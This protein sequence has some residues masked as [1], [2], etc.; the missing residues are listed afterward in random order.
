M[1]PCNRRRATV[2]ESVQHPDDLDL[3]SATQPEP[4]RLKDLGS[5]SPSWG[6]HQE[7][8]LCPEVH[9]VLDVESQLGMEDPS[10]SSKMLTQHGNLPVLEAVDVAISQEV[11]LPSVE[12]SHSLTVHLDKGRLQA[13]A[14][15]K[16]KKIVFQPGQVT[17]EDP[18]DHPVI[19]EPT[20]LGEPGEVKAE[21]GQHFVSRR[22]KITFCAPSD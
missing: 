3:E 18:G 16:S 5:E 20:L 4:G 22:S 9:S 1:V 15:R 12:S 19:E 13:T 2:T 17:R 10:H 6:Q 7:S 8:S 14:S 11:T 21:G